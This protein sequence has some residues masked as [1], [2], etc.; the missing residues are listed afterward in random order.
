[1]LPSKI[2]NFIAFSS[3]FKLR[4]C[5]SFAR[6]SFSNLEERATSWNHKT[7]FAA[8]EILWMR[9][10]A[11]QRR[12]DGWGRGGIFFFNIFLFFFWCCLLIFSVR[13]RSRQSSNKQRQRV[14]WEEDGRHFPIKLSSKAVFGGWRQGGGSGWN[15]AWTFQEKVE[16]K[17][18]WIFFSFR[19]FSRRLSSLKWKLF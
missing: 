9:A 18:D 10:R 5:S 17:L 7:M 19:V 3:C 2:E 14:K 11:L 15:V 16:C 12:M 4:I 6:L 1:M 8:T 13:R